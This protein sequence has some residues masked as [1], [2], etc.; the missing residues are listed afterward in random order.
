MK[1]AVL[2]NGSGKHLDITQ[3]LFNHWN[4]LY[5]DISFDF[6]LATWQDE[7]DYTEYKWIKSYVR[8]KEE[9]CPY[10][11]STHP[12]GQHQPHYS[13]SLYKADQLRKES[14]IEY[15]GVFQTRSDI[16]IFRELLDLLT[17][18]YTVK[19]GVN[20][21]VSNSQVAPRI[22]FT[23][24]GNELLNGRFWTEDYFFFGHPKAFDKFSNMFI[25][26]W[27]KNELPDRLKLMHVMQAEY[28]HKLG[29][30]NS[31][32]ANYPGHAV[33]SVLIREKHRF[34]HH[35]THTDAGWEKQHPSP[36]QLKTLI[37]QN[38]PEHLLTR[39]IAPKAIIYF[40]STDK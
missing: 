39:D 22:M 6:Y 18:L 36:K 12:E 2:I 13:Y 28:L 8:L 19:Q 21:D 40:E 11:L 7:I 35:S 33:Q 32:I 31:S 29:I 30:Y 3:H 16:Y 5:E 34:G 25:D 1:I 15:D 37:A 20:Q 38:G 17:S 10:D 26:V 9:S 4:K 23:G 14:G 24:S 27:I